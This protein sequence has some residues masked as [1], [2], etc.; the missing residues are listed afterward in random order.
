[1]KYLSYIILFVVIQSCATRS[2]NL[3][4][5]SV[6]FDKEIDMSRFKKVQQYDGS[7]VYFPADFAKY[8]DQKHLKSLDAD[9]YLRAEYSDKIVFIPK[10]KALIREIQA[11]RHK[12]KFDAIAAPKLEVSPHRVDVIVVGDDVPTVGESIRAKAPKQQLKEDENKKVI[13]E[14]KREPNR[15][16]SH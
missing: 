2:Q 7:I 10:N 1:M 6:F 5:Q 11:G 4:D 14:I 16:L 13:E 15:L 9:D 8:V 12:E 3:A